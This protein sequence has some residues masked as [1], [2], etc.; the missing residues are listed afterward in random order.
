MSGRVA[1]AVLYLA[2]DLKVT[3][4]I[5]G[6]TKNFFPVIFHLSPLICVRKQ[7]VT[8]KEDCAGI[9]VRKPGRIGRCI[10]YRDMTKE[11]ESGVKLNSI[12]QML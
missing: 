9:D 5:P 8:W 12:K 2:C 11:V 6:R 7:S 1:Q 3:G 10:D 4:S